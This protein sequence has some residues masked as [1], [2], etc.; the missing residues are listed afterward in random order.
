MLRAVE[1]YDHSPG[2][3]FATYATWWIRKAI[4]RALAEQPRTIRLPAHLTDQL[5]RVA[6]ARRKLTA[7]LDRAPRSDELAAALDIPLR[8][9]LDLLALAQEPLSLDQP[10]GADGGTLGELLARPDELEAPGIALLRNE[11]EAVLGTLTPREQQVIRLRCG[12]D[13]GR[14]R[15]LAEVGHEL[16]VT[17]ERIRQ[18]EHRIL[19]KLREPARADR[20]LAYVS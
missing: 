11:V 4:L 2:F 1:K 5:A 18:L 8:Q 12:F 13:D 9:L 20:L 16:G 15:T 17:R 7:E 10:V 19:R 6:Q 3:R 14:Q